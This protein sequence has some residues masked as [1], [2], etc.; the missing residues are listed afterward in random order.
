MKTKL[1][2]LL[3]TLL[4]A[5]LLVGCSESKELKEFRTAFDTFCTDVADLDDSINAID[6]AAEDAPAQLLTMLDELD[7]KFQELAALKIPQEF[8]YMENLA[9]EASENMTLA[10]ENYH[11]AFESEY[12][13]SYTANI[14]SQ[15]YERA[16]K[17]IQYMIT[18]MHGDVPDDENVQMIED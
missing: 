18:F 6:A 7:V 13:D 10:V 15:Y 8:S 1:Y 4:F 2:I 11:T 9:D 16:Y 14:A 3:T 5:F 17:R 12:Y